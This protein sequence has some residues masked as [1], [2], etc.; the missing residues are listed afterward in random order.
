MRISSGGT[1]IQGNERRQFAVLFL[2]LQRLLCVFIN[3][4]I[5]LKVPDRRPAARASKSNSRPAAKAAR[6]RHFSVRDP[7]VKIFVVAF[8]CLG[9]AIVSVFGYLYFKYERVVDRRMA[10]GIFSDAA[11]IYARPPVI[12][13]GEKMEASRDCGPV[14]SRR[15]CGRKQREQFRHR[16]L[17][18]VTRR[19]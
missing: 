2:R 17:H 7:L 6:V 11:K 5:K 14:A 1:G 16:T 4:A 13:V 8:L 12:S 15:I 9:L 10:G 18:L 3:V 19:A